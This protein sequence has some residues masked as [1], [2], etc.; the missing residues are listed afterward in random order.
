MPG[1]PGAPARRGAVELLRLDRLDEPANEPAIE[2]SDGALS[3]AS[4]EPA[5]EA[6]AGASDEPQGGA[7]VEGTGEATGEAPTGADARIARITR[8]RAEVLGLRLA[9]GQGRF[10]DPPVATLPKADAD[11]GQ[12]PF[13]VLV[14]GETA[15][16][17]ILNRSVPSGTGIVPG[18]GSSLTAAPER[19]V[20]LRSFLIEVRWQG[21][22]VARRACRLLPPLAREAVPEAEEILATVK[23]AN[24]AGYRAYIAGGFEDTGRRYLGADAGVQHVLSMPLT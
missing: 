20:M 10:V 6:L 1:A 14:D 2:A 22:G 13:A 9:P 8:V 15:G 19:A 24:P 4:G 17:G 18:D 16:F 3:G 12:V 23:A 5:N 11:P 21:E 7:A